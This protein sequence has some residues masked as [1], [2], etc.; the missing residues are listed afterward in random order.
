MWGTIEQ[1]VD[2]C[3]VVSGGAVK[4]LIPIIHWGKVSEARRQRGRG[5]EFLPVFHFRPMW[6][7]EF[8]KSAVVKY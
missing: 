2:V 8:S 1:A 7:F 3:E 5:G 4:A 6:S